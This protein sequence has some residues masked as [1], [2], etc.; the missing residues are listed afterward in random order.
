MIE[1]IHNSGRQLVLAVTGG[2]SQAIA[3]L[4]AVP[5]ASASVLEAVV[6]YSLPALEDWLGGRVDHACSER[7]ARAMAMA[8]FRRTRYLSSNSSAS[9]SAVTDSSLAR[10]A[11]RLAPSMLVG[12]GATASVA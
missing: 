3:D 8:A 2:G 11:S 4:L 10:S 5:G 12:I 7:T 9:S 6:P 1:R